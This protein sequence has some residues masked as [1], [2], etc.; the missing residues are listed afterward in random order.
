MKPERFNVFLPPTPCT[1]HFSD[2]VRAF[3]R[4]NGI[5][6]AHLQRLALENFLTQNISKTTQ[7]IS[8]ANDTAILEG[9]Q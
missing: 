2:R 3:A 6:L 7:D 8:L 4:A 5:S 1:P 9:S